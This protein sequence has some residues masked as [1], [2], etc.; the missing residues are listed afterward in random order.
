MAITKTDLGPNSAS[1]T[2][3]GTDTP[4]AIMAALSAYITEHG[5][6]LFDSGNFVI[7]GISGTNP[8][9]YVFRALQEGS[10]TVYKYV[11]ICMTNNTMTLR[12]FE[13]WNEVTH[14]GTGDGSLYNYGASNPIQMTHIASNVGT[15]GSKFIIFANRKWL[16]FRTAT[17][18][19]VYSHMFGAFE[20]KK[21]FGEAA[22]IP[23]NVFMTTYTSTMAPISGGA[24]CIYGTYSGATR[25]AAQSAAYYN[26]I[27]TPYGVPAN[28]SSSTTAVSFGDVMP[29]TPGAYSMIAAEIANYYTPK[30]A[31]LR[32]RIMG[33]KLGHGTQIW[34]DMDTAS[35][36]CD[37]DFFDTSTGTPIQYHIC[38]GGSGYTRY[39]IPA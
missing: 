22:N 5:W 11:G 10:T 28:R 34:N 15:A 20:I 13:S 8:A 32:G 12:T 4:A 29:D 36:K 19:N 27:V 7:G 37:A 17:A 26:T 23:T 30:I 21:E 39:L 31:V 24:I 25:T 3:D 2:I 16:A 18:A 38:H 35:I 14:V 33:I 9:S 6:T 1:F